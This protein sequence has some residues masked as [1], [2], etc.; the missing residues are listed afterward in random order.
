MAEGRRQMDEAGWFGRLGTSHT[1]ISGRQRAAPRRRGPPR[2]RVTPW[3]AGRNKIRN[4]AGLIDVGPAPVALEDDLAPIAAEND[5]EV[6][7]PDRRRVTP[8]H[9][10]GCGFHLKRGRQGF[11]LDL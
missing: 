6:A 1:H 8:A 11:D 3:S 4:G 5:L 2:T 9:G 7:S 10:A